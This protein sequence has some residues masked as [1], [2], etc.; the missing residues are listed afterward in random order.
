MAVSIPQVSAA[1]VCGKELR[2]PQRLFR[3]NPNH[4]FRSSKAGRYLFCAFLSGKSIP[5]K[6][7]E[8]DGYVWKREITQVSHCNIV[9]VVII[10]P[11]EHNI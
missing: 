1:K 10:R 5:C 11:H 2:T 6:G 7:C 4:F 3:G 8:K 9:F